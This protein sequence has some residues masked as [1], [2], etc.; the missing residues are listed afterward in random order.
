M[1][2][3]T[4]FFEIRDEATCIP[5][6]CTLMEST[7]PVDKSFLRRSGYGP[8][9]LLVLYFDLNTNRGGYDSHDHKSKTHRIAH[10][11]I[12]ENWDRLSNGD[13]IDVGFITGNSTS[14][15]EPEIYIEKKS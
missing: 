15:K 6:L 12:Q 13:V 1:S 7:S 3:P 11:Y 10:T 4:K 8:G 5:V 2:L 9:Q 14:I